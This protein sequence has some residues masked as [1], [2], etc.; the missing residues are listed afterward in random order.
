MK[1]EEEDFKEK[2]VS[3]GLRVL[4]ISLLK[5]ISW[6]PFPVMYG[7][8]DLMA[9]LLHRVI[10]YRRKVIYTNLRLSFPDKRKP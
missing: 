2:K 8:S 10:R 9:V 6:L 4:Y 1:M 7:L 3:H 5:G